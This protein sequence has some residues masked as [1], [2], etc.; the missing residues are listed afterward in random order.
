MESN[1]LRSQ[2]ICSSDSYITYLTDNGL[3]KVHN[4]LRSDPIVKGSKIYL[5]LQ[6]ALHSPDLAEISIGSH[7]CSQSELEMLSYDE[8]NRILIVYE[9]DHAGR[10][11]EAL[12]SDIDIRTDIT[13]LAN[14]IRKWAFFHGE[15]F[16][17]LADEI[18]SESSIPYAITSNDQQLVAVNGILR[19]MFSY[20]WGVP[21]A[22]KTTKVLA[23]GVEYHFANN[24]KVLLTAPT[25]SALDRAL[26]S[27]VQVLMA[28]GFDTESI[29]RLGIPSQ[30]F[31]EQ[32]PDLCVDTSKG[33]EAR[34]LCRRRMLNA[35]MV[36][37]TVDSYTTAFGDDALFQPDHIYLDEAGYCPLIKML[38]LMSAGAALTLLGD[39]MQLPPVCSV[40]Q[41][42]IRNDPC[43]CL[44]A[45]SAV[46]CENL[47]ASRSIE[48]LAHGYLNNAAPMFN[49]MKRF[50]LFFSYRFGGRLVKVLAHH[51]YGNSF[52]G[53][54][55]DSPK[56]TV[57]DAGCADISTGRTNPAEA[58]AIMRYLQRTNRTDYVVLTP[59]NK[60][61]VLLRKLLKTD[62]EHV[63][64]IH[65]AQG[66]EWNTVILSIVDAQ[67][68]F[69]TNSLRHDTH[70][71]EVINTALSRAKSELVIACDVG[72]WKTQHGQLIS[73]IV[74][75]ALAVA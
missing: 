25:N 56:I 59:Y 63:M 7:C 54:E 42:A 65:Q 27:V 3:D 48:E 12:A 66:R 19:S 21:G 8:K 22:G 28:D 10:F 43:L 37:V 30:D 36:A 29:L 41:S 45:Q 52:H 39:H 33:D 35:K 44:W 47:F 17:I 11:S 18:S 74:T 60:Q 73:S 70:G 24:E 16:S 26:C 38:P 75:E 15:S 34:A 51:V 2:I 6:K 20:V 57:L 46:Y 23:Q 53:L 64:T 14:N 67:N 13:F 68:M 40:T 5:P 50:D 62:E 32:Y 31:R 58:H 72:F 71:L 1:E 49:K 55:T 69:F 9:R 61:A 4:K